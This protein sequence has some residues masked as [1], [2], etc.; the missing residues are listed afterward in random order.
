MAKH[1]TDKDISNVVE[2]LDEWSTDSKLTW[3]RLVEAVKYNYKLVTTRQTLEKQVR[4]KI[5]FVEVKSIVSGNGGKAKNSVRSLPP[6]LKVAAERLN[7]Q[8]RK[9]ARLELEN[10]RLLEQFQVW[11]YNAYLHDITIDQLN[12]PLPTKDK[13]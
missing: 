2:L 9:I 12:E 8:E 1:L 6:S 13:K 5:A 10:Q 3:D 7:T 11:L 4:I